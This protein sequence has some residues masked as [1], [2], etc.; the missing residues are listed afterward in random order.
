MPWRSRECVERGAFR[1]QENVNYMLVC[2]YVT[3][4]LLW[5]GKYKLHYLRWS[6]LRAAKA[7]FGLC[8]Y[9]S[10]GARQPCMVMKIIII[11]IEYRSGRQSGYNLR[12][13]C[14][15]Y[16]NRLVFLLRRSHKGQSWLAYF[17]GSCYFLLYI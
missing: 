10:D 17:G 6:N 4:L 9:F 15:W 5:Q 1:A 13:V 14:A 16:G 11:I 8:M 7:I 3:W 2:E 12:R